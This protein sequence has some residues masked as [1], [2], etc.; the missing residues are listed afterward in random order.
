M[1]AEH[2]HFRHGLASR[3]DRR[4]RHANGCDATHAAYGNITARATCHERG[5][6][7]APRSRVKS[8]R[9]HHRA[10]RNRHT[11]RCGSSTNGHVESRLSVSTNRRQHR[12]NIGNTNGRGWQR[13]S[14]SGTTRRHQTR[15]S[16][17]STSGRRW[18]RIR[19]SGTDHQRHLSVRATSA[20]RRRSEAPN[21]FRARSDGAQRGC[22]QTDFEISNTN[23]AASTPGT[24]CRTA[25]SGKASTAPGRTG[26]RGGLATSA[27]IHANIAR[28]VTNRRSRGGGG[29]D[30]RNIAA[31]CGRDKWKARRLAISDIAI[32]DCAIANPDSRRGAGGE[33]FRGCHAD[34]YRH[35]VNILTDARQHERFHGPRRANGDRHDGKTARGC[36]V[37]RAANFGRGAVTPTVPG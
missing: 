37:S 35:R 15:I 5:L 6:N 29:D 21:H 36:L 20:R 10:Q 25:A 26:N 18:R 9:A 30:R 23:G 32:Q 28:V 3:A 14:V 33:N 4:R 19:V 24:R 1:G 22:G 16:V 7:C 2:V 31:I 27:D 17:D 11:P 34:F 12:I 13:L 8:R